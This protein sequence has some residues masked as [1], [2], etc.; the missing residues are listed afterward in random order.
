MCF[1]RDADGMRSGN[2]RTVSHSL[3]KYVCFA[4]KIVVCIDHVGNSLRAH[5]TKVIVQWIL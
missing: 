2:R 1:N 4:F 3:K 5:K